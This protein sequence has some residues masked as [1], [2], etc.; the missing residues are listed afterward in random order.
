MI[1][2]FMIFVGGLLSSA[3]CV[4]MCGGFALALGAGGRSHAVNLLRQ[5]VYG[6]G[7]V[8]T[9]TVFGVAAGYAGARLTADWQPLMNVQAV[10]SIAAGL[11]LIALGLDAAGLLRW[12]RSASS[13]ACLGAD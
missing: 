4:G 6:L 8:F 5:L 2:W 11:A 12:P 7:R 3:H 10:L 13:S 9:Y 1:G